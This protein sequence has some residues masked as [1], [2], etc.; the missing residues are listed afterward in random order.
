MPGRMTTPIRV[1]TDRLTAEAQAKLRVI[2]DVLSN[3]G[4]Q[5]IIEAK[6]NGS[7]IDQTGNLRSSI[8]YAVLFDGQVI[9]SGTMGKIKGRI[10]EGDEGVSEGLAFLEQR[11]RKA[12]KQGVRLIVTAGMNYAEYVEAKGR[13][14][15]SSAEQMAPALVRQLLTELGFKC[16]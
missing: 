10:G 12:R 6:N 11:I 2:A 16:K 15:L 1:I 5:C 4:E 14:V 7:Y 3:V 13:V 9:Q 8:G